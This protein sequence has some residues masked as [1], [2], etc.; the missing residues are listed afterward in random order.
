M[1]KKLK[2]EDVIDALLVDLYMLE[3]PENVNGKL[4]VYLSD[5]ENSMKK[6]RGV[7]ED[8]YKLKKQ[9]Q[10]RFLRETIVDGVNPKYTCD[11]YNGL[12]VTEKCKQYPVCTSYQLKQSTKYIGK[13]ED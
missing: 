5:V 6:M 7:V 2:T 11:M 9:K 12:P 8:H 10:C 13:K 1:T 3:N 4:V